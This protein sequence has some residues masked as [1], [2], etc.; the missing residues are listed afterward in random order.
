MNSIIYVF[1]ALIVGFIIGYLMLI[2]RAKSD[3]KIQDVQSR[4]VLEFENLAN[5]IFEEKG[6]KFAQ[7]N[8]LNL[9]HLLQPLGEKLKLFEN[10]VNEVYDKDN[11]ERINLKVQI[12]ELAKLNKEMNEETRNLTN[13]LKGDTKIQ[14]NWGEMILESI[15]QK[16]GLTKDREYFVQ[17]SMSQEGQRY[18]PDVIISLPENKSLII[19]SKVSLIA[20]ERFMSCDKDSSQEKQYLK[21][22]VLSMRNHIKSLNNKSYQNLYGLKTLDFV[23]MFVPIE[24]AYMLAINKDNL[25]IDEALHNNIIIVCPSTLLATLRTISNIWKTEKSLQNANQIAQVG[26]ELYDRFVG[27]LNELDKVKKLL[28]AVNMNYDSAITKLSGNKGVIKSVI[29]LS[30]L[31]VKSTKVLD[32]KWLEESD[33]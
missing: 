15:L 7:Q 12:E 33:N 8:Q 21:E 9:N 29:K 30:E 4:F 22:H 23:L 32:N 2:L 24:A 5:R 28:E 20:Y 14:G 13:A 18:R 25:L 1:I 16:S 26:G 10:K 3:Q 19:D 11:K 17:L 6:Y 31:G 27:F